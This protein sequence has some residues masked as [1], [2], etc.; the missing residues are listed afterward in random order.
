MWFRKVALRSAVC[1]GGWGSCSS[2]RRIFRISEVPFS[3]RRGPELRNRARHDDKPQVKPSVSFVSGEGACS[4]G[5]I[6]SVEGKDALGIRGLS[7]GEAHIDARRQQ[8][9]LCIDLRLNHGVTM[10][11]EK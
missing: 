10:K 7:R 1:G 6:T 4:P 3:A 8:L 5:K 11:E 2:R 9:L